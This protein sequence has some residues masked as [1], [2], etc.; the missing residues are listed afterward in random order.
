VA[1]VYQ[2]VALEASRAQHG[3]DK[4]EMARKGLDILAT[5]RTAVTSSH[6]NVHGDASADEIIAYHNDNMPG[7]IDTAFRCFD[8][9]KNFFRNDEIGRSISVVF[10]FAGLIVIGAVVVGPIEGWTFLESVYFSVVSLTTVGFGDYVP[11]QLSSI[12]FC[13]C[14]LPF[15]VGFMSLYLGNVAA[16]Y[17]RL[18]D[19]NIHR[20][21]RQMRRRV[22]RAKA[23]AEGERSEVLRRAYRGQEVE[24]EAVAAA[25]EDE[26]SVTEEL[27]S[28]KI[29][30]QHAKSA[31]GRRR[32]K[33][34]GFD[35]L[36]GNDPLELD[37]GSD[38]HSL[39]GSTPLEN[40]S[41]KRRQRILED[42][43]ASI[44][45]AA[46][47]DGRTMQSMRDIVRAVRRNLTESQ[48][49]SEAASAVVRTGPDVQFMSIRSTQTMPS[50]T[51]LRRA[52]RKPSF[53]LR[54]LIQERFAEIIATELA[55][56]QSSIEIKDNTLSVTIDS[57]QDT[58]DK[59]LIPGRA[60]KAFRAVAFEGLYFVGE[61]GLITRGA[62]ALYDLSPFEFHGLFSPLVA[63]MGDAE[64][65]EG[66]LASTDILADVDLRR[67]GTRPG[68]GGSADNNRL[69][70]AQ[71][72]RRN[73]VSNRNLN[74]TL[75]HAKLKK[76]SPGGAF[77]R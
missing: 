74:E 45:S 38:T 17:I 50:H 10:P 34:S 75:D 44:G 57:M 20:I 70:T 13:V 46:R 1:Q 9:A 72:E 4:T 36:P 64:T 49:P 60:R 69:T 19:R 22:M 47:P 67:D 63:A 7:V 39:F 42:S 41:G 51:M 37:D 43:S 62:D 32:N 58:A 2:C 5:S 66:W 27:V 35:A 29:P 76:N 28:A 18:S 73:T 48:K 6:G 14:W 23:K 68:I 59:W 65:M 31:L 52:T 25:S 53:A 11:T 26:A 40:V 33:K 24:L 16:F 71:Q 56:F 8:R 3:R 77:Q 61:H 15:S 12:W 54:V 30:S 21:E 55:G